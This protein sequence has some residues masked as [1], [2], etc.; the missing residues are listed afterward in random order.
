MIQKRER[1]RERERERVSG[2]MKPWKK[3]SMDKW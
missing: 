2:Q 1:E 3:E